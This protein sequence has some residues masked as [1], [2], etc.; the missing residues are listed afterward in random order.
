V[1]LVYVRTLRRDS[2]VI[3]SPLQLRALAGSQG[4]IRTTEWLPHGHRR[5]AVTSTIGPSRP[6]AHALPITFPCGPPPGPKRMFITSRAASGAYEGPGG[7]G[8]EH[9]DP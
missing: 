1:P 2:T 9:I 3:A 5:R 8:R 7:R 6:V 4:D